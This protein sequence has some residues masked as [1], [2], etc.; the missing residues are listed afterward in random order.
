MIER[1]TIVG[2]H[3]PSRVQKPGFEGTARA[4]S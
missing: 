3:V 4:V 1:S 2:R